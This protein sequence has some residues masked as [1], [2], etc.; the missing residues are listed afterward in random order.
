LGLGF[1]LPNHANALN[2][3]FGTLTGYFDASGDSKGSELKFDGFSNYVEKLDGDAPKKGGLIK[4]DDQ[5][6]V[7]IVLIMKLKKQLLFFV[8]VILS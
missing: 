8:D 3:I 6:E 7:I 5:E 2:D 4:P 1:R